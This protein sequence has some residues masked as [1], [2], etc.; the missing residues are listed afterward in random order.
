[1]SVTPSAQRNPGDRL[2]ARRDALVAGRGE[3]EAVRERECA[4]LSVVITGSN[5]SGAPCVRAART[6]DS[7]LLVDERL[8]ERV[9]TLG[10]AA[11]DAHELVDQLG[12][13]DGADCRIAGLE[14][15]GHFVRRRFVL[16]QRDERGRVEQ[17]HFRRRSA[18]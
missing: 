15:R 5:Q 6:S 7:E 11:V 16:R 8:N 4:G 9:D 17:D 2:I 10:V 14:D 1:M 18:A 3:Q 13:V 12:E